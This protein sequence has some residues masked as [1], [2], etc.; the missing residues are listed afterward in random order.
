[1]LS[2]RGPYTWRTNLLS[3]EPHWTRWFEGLSESFLRA[4]CARMLLL[5]GTD[6]LDTP[7]IV[8][9]MQGK[10]Q[11]LLNPQCGHVIMEDQPEQ[12]ARQLLGTK[13]KEENKNQNQMII[14]LLL[15][16]FFAC[17]KLLC[18]VIVDLSQF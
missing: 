12:T 7:L 18:N 13:K 11:L 16:L 15:P 14:F 8:G 1:M 6:R 17:K 3:S 4:P 10:F 2:T 5:A 9:Q